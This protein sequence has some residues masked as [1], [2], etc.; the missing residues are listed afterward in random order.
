[1]SE[2]S[3]EFPSPTAIK[4]TTAKQKKDTGDQAFKAGQVKEGE[5]YA[6]ICLFDDLILACRSSEVI[7]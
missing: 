7:S 2:V 1:M 3:S 6:V 4:V 5:S